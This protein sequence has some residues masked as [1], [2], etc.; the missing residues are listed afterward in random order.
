[1]VQ[2][3]NK[4]VTEC[5]KISHGELFFVKQALVYLERVGA[6]KIKIVDLKR[7]ELHQA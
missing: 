3:I 1:M 7:E 2:T 4:K 5:D 6:E